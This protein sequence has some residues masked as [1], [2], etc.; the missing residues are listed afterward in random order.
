MSKRGQMPHCSPYM[1]WEV[2][3]GGIILIG[4]L[5]LALLVHAICSL[6]V[7]IFLV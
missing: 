6:K 2:G 4:A 5:F 3:S 7:R 1:A